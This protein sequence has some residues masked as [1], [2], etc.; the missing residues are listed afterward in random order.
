[1]HHPHE[2]TIQ[3]AHTAWHSFGDDGTFPNNAAL[4]VVVYKGALYLHPTEDADAIRTVFAGH[5]WT[6]SWTDG[7]FSYHHYHSI[8]HEVLGVFCG[9]A[10]VQL[11]GPEG[12]CVELV[13]GDVVVIPAGVA[14]KCLRST[15]DFVVV[16][17][18]AGGRDYDINYGKEEERAEALANIPAVPVPDTDPVYGAEGPL[19]TKWKKA[20]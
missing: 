3:K 5:G 4:P 7:I 15:P 13:R 16:G 1:M 18:Y 12:T 17:A 11:G 8:A 19:L 20:G 2:Q 6:N 10:D 14:H 9:R